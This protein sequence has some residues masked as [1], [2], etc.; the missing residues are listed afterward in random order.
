MKKYEPNKFRYPASGETDKLLG[1]AAA[2]GMISDQEPLYKSIL[3]QIKE[4][5]MN[6]SVGMM[7][8]GTKSDSRAGARNA[9]GNVGEVIDD[10]TKVSGKAIDSLENNYELKQQFKEL[11]KV[12]KSQAEELTFYKEQLEE[13]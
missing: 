5:R 3:G 11:R 6:E 10:P 2:Q 13:A 8:R 7:L 12:T 9:R 4:P 1:Q